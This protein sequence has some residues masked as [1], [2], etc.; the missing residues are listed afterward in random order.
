MTSPSNAVDVESLLAAADDVL[1]QYEPLVLGD[2]A[3]AFARASASS[4]S[5]FSSSCSSSWD[6]SIGLFSI[7]ADDGEAAAALRPLTESL[8]DVV[9][10]NSG[11]VMVSSSRL[12][13]TTTSVATVSKHDTVTKPDRKARRRAQAA[14][15]SGRYRHRKKVRMCP[16]GNAVQVLLG[17]HQRLSASFTTLA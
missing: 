4:S 13:A 2:A 17:S 11:R 14:S 10:A 5:P 6:E 3:N 1:L 7:D 15:S 9:A 8:S 16:D 12:P